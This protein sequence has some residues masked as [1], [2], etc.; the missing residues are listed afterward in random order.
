VRD[1]FCLLDENVAAGY[2]H[3]LEM[4]SQPVADFRVQTAQQ[5]IGVQFTRRW[6]L[7]AA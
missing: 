2:F 7:H 1:G 4:F 6:R 5:L 3:G